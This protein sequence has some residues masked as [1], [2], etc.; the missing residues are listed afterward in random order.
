MEEVEGKLKAQKCFEEEY[1]H[2]QEMYAEA[3]IENL[4]EDQFFL[5]M[6]ERDD[7]GNALLKMGDEATEL[8]NEYPFIQC[9]CLLNCSI[10]K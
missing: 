6:F 10:D 4:D 5:A 9:K 1:Q 8:Y 7:E 3:F 2:R